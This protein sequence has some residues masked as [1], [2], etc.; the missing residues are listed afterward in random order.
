VIVDFK[1]GV[2][3]HGIWPPTQDPAVAAALLAGFLDGRAWRM[4]ANAVRSPHADLTSIIQRAD[5][6]AVRRPVA[7]SGV[8][9]EFD[10]DAAGLFDTRV[11]DTFLVLHERRLRPMNMTWKPPGFSSMVCPGARTTPFSSSRIRIT[12]P[13]IFIS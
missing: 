10:I 4:A 8:D 3:G 6:G 1:R 5:L 12:A 13:S 9:L 2:L 11:A 7:P